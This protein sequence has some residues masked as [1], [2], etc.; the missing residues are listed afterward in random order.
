MC[1]TNNSS[2][3]SSDKQLCSVILLMTRIDMFKASVKVVEIL[4]ELERIYPPA[5]FDI[6]IHLPIHLALEA[7]E[8][9]PIHPRSVNVH[10][11]HS[12]DPEV[13]TTSRVISLA[14]G[15]SR[16]PMS[17]N[18]CCS[19]MVLSTWRG[20]VV[21][22][23]YPVHLLQ[24]FEGCARFF[25]NRGKGKRKAQ[26]RRRESRHEDPG[27]DPEPSIRRIG[28]RATKGRPHRDR[29]EDLAD[30]TV[31]IS[32]ITDGA[33]VRGSDERRW[34]TNR[35]ALSVC[36]WKRCMINIDYLQ[37]GACEKGSIGSES[38]GS[39]WDYP[40]AMSGLGCE[41]GAERQFGH[42]SRDIEQEVEGVQRAMDQSCGRSLSLEI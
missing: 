8:G 16:T 36:S 5:F 21:V 22:I 10:A 19:R 29:F 20:T 24:S 14:N 3:H 6:M 4:C 35:D 11:K 18:A 28:G 2:Y 1:K 42:E 41:F 26:F 12:P 38:L 37:R 34:P 40:V 17:V 15:P 33:A 27:N 31:S 9:G 13:I 25:I 32:G 30:N 23:S 39:F 7:L